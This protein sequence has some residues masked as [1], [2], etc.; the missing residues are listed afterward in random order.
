MGICMMTERQKEANFYMDRL[1]ANATVVARNIETH[2]V[3]VEIPVEVSQVVKQQTFF[4]PMVS[5]S[6]GTSYDAYA[7]DN[8]M[9]V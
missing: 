1:E 5:V 7:N 3:H 8:C 4:A 6:S 9:Q 2:M